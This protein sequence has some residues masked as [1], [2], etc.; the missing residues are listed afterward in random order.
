MYYVNIPLVIKFQFSE[1]L[2]MLLLSARDKPAQSVRKYGNKRSLI[3]K[4]NGTVS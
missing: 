3:S 2:E 4:F 1:N